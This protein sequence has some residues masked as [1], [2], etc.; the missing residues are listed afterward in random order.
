MHGIVS[1][2][3]DVPVGEVW[4]MAATLG[5]KAR[6]YKSSTRFWGNYRAFQGLIQCY[7]V[8]G[9]ARSEAPAPSQGSVK[10]LRP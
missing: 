1:A 4:P 9:S 10:L 7:C 2:V 8:A 6:V 3:Y 5:V